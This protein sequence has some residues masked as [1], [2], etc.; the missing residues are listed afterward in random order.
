MDGVGKRSLEGGIIV[1]AYRGVVS[2]GILDYAYFPYI[3]LGFCRVPG[4]AFPSSYDDN[5]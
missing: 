2:E 1:I 3:F 5:Y 4:V